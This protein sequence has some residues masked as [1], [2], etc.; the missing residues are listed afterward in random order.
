MGRGRP[1]AVIELTEN[2]K[3]DLRRLVRRRKTS[4]ALALRARIVLAAAAGTSTEDIAKKLGVCDDTASKW[5]TRFAR[6]G[7]DGIC[8]APRSGSPRRVSDDKLAEII[9]V[10]LETKP[11]G[12]THWSCR[13]LEAKVGISHSTI[14]RVWRS[15]GLQPHRSETFTLSTD[16]FFVEKVVDIVGLYLNPPQNAVVLCVDEKSQIQALDRTQP[17]LPMLPGQVERQTH[18]YSR[19]GTTSL[20]AALDV[21]TGK[22]IAQCHRRHR[23]DEFLRF[24][25]RIDKDTPEQLD[26]HVV[27]DN[28]GT[29]K[30]ASVKKWLARHSR[31][32]P[33]FTPTY[34]S[35][36]NLVER[37]FALLTERQL[38][39]GVHR[40]TKALE[41]AIMEFVDA[42][43][44]KPKPMKWTKNAEEIFE[45]IRRFI[46]RISDTPH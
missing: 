23:A 29:H 25:R 8:D 4:Q 2:E 10:T 43:N 33:H 7:L 31:F 13:L 20:F 27:M 1:P 44:D 18:T 39:R 35:W 21:A 16:P 12:A 41:E 9:R 17:L 14:G 37:Y 5:R 45:S 3:V 11:K 46:R 15:F 6:L 34:S 28:Y 32:T 22:V 36:L 38:K 42:S 19:Y 30:T 40:S 26:I 24:L